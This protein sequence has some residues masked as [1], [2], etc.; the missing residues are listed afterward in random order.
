MKNNK[1]RKKAPK[2]TKKFLDYLVGLNYGSQER[3][4]DGLGKKAHTGIKENGTFL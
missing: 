1:L 3:G 4:K 2:Y